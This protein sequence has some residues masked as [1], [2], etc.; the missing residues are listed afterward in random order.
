MTEDKKKDENSPLED[1]VLG[2]DTVAIFDRVRNGLDH[3]YA[4]ILNEQGQD[5]VM[6]RL[7]LGELKN[8]MSRAPV[9]CAR[10]MSPALGVVR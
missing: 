1:R 10:H 9:Y 7:L 4:E 3:I 8:L 5:T 6:E 2:G